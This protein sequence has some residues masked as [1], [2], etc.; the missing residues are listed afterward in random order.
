MFKSLHDE[1]LFIIKFGIC[2]DFFGFRFELSL[3]DSWFKDDFFGFHL[4]L[5]FGDS[6]SFVDNHCTFG[7]KL[8]IQT[9]DGFSSLFVSNLLLIKHTFISL[10]NDFL[11]G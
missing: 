5:S 2:H 8:L 11:F 7:F 9:S 6:F 3:F 4:S 10:F 1:G